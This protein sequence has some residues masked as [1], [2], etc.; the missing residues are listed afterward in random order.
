[1]ESDSHENSEYF[2]LGSNVQERVESRFRMHDG[3]DGFTEKILLVMSNAC[4]IFHEHKWIKRFHIHTIS[5]MLV[6]FPRKSVRES[7]RTVV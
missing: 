4:G 3:Y 6:S 1:M 7:G 5:G 2:E